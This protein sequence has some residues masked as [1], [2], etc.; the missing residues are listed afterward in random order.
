MN[1]LRPMVTAPALFLAVSLSACGGPET[2]VVE[3]ADGTSSVYGENG[4]LFDDTWGREECWADGGMFL[5]RGWE[6]DW[7]LVLPPAD[8]EIP[9]VLSDGRVESEVLRRVKAMDVTELADLL[10]HIVGRYGDGSMGN[11]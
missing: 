2:T 6:P 1:A 10:D 3:R 7:C 8:Y 11:E 5:D 9:V 4:E